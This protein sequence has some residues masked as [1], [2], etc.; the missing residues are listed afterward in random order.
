MPASHQGGPYLLD[1][2]IQKEGGL[3]TIDAT[4]VTAAN[5]PRIARSESTA[6]ANFSGYAESEDGETSGSLSFDYYA[7][8]VTLEY[9]L[10]F[11]NTFS[12]TPSGSIG[13]AAFNIRREGAASLV[14]IAPIETFAQTRNRIGKV[15]RISITATKTIEQTGDGLTIAGEG[16]IFG[17]SL[18]NL[19]E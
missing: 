9:A 6:K 17:A 8:S 18:N 11:P 1:R 12:V 3:T 2:A 13:A 5:P 15:A 14:S 4:Y 19:W 16:G 7:T 10:V